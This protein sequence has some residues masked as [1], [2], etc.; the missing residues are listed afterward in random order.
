MEHINLI[1]AFI[2]QELGI[3]LS[4]ED[5]KYLDK[6]WEGMR[7]SYTSKFYTYVDGEEGDRN[8]N[9][10]RQLHD[11]TEFLLGA[12]INEGGDNTYYIF[13]DYFIAQCSVL[14]SNWIDVKI[15]LIYISKKPILNL[16]TKLQ[17]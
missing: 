14:V 17:N 11:N 8:I 2:T 5:V 15:K 7:G 13:T 3:N 12:Y 1:N 9:E 16:K 10:F 4:L 6:V